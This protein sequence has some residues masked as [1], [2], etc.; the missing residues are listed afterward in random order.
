MLKIV[1][2]LGLL[3]PTMAFGQKLPGNFTC[4]DLID[5]AEGKVS[6]TNDGGVTYVPINVP[7]PRDAFGQALLT[8]DTYLCRRLV[9]G[10][11][12]A[13]EFDAL[14]AE[15][16]HQMNGD[17]HKAL[18]DRKNLENQERVI[19]NQRAII[20]NQQRATQTQ[21]EA[22]QVQREGVQVQRDAAVIQ[23]LQAEAWRQ[24]QDAQ[25]QELMRQQRV[26]QQMQQRQLEQI[27]Q[28]QSRPR[29]VTCFGGGNYIH[30]N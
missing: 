30:C 1:L 22:V 20:Q 21:Q 16:A 2:M 11:I 12:G 9:R 24:Q 3:L 25:H 27:R 17:R 10:E 19:Q 18:V 5:S 29:S 7:R 15:K 4:Q 14:H 13:T 28:E 23:A 6:R 26:Q 8:H